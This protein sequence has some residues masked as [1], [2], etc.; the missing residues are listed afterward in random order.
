MKLRHNIEVGVAYGVPGGQWDT[1]FVEVVAQD[2]VSLAKLEERALAGA[3]K[4]LE[5][6][7]AEV[8][9]V[10]VHCLNED[11]AEEVDEG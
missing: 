5:R 2:N 7:E 3:L 1:I 8:G 6:S 11:E 9:G 4:E 10:W